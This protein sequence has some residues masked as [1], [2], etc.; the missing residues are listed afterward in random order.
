MVMSGHRMAMSIALLSLAS[1]SG[2]DTTPQT[3]PVP[4]RA[5]ALVT[6]SGSE[7]GCRKDEAGRAV[8]LPVVPV[9]TFDHAPDGVLYPETQVTGE[10]SKEAAEAIRLFDAG[11]WEAAIPGLSDVVEG[12]TRDYHNNR[13]IAQFDLA[14][15][16][17]NAKRAK[18]ALPTFASVASDASRL[19]YLD[20]CD[21]LYET[22]ADS[23]ITLDLAIDAFYPSCGTRLE[24]PA[25]NPDAASEFGDVRNAFMFFCGRGALRRGDLQTAQND[26]LAIQQASEFSPLAIDCR[27]VVLDVAAKDVHPVTPDGVR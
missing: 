7:L 6:R 1:C 10:P 22:L 3:P 14:V 17:F 16:E 8:Q 4:L 18:L 20:A 25:T 9:P 5:K 15:A 23:R 11:K 26:F 2:A 24:P 27:R 19:R 12:K 13:E 21:F